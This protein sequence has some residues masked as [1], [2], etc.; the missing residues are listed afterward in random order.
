MLRQ[1]TAKGPLSLVTAE[2]AFAAVCVTFVG[3]GLQPRS[4][5]FFQVSCVLYDAQLL[6]DFYNKS[7][8]LIGARDK[9]IPLEMAPDLSRPCAPAFFRSVRIEG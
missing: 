3:E 8:K 9:M 7:L 2:R 1:I 5:D 4:A 6:E